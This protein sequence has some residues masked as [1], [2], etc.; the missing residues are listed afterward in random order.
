MRLIFLF[1]AS[2][3][4]LTSNLKAE[5]RFG[6]LTNL[7]DDRMRG[8]DNQWVR[9]HPGPFV[10]NN[11]EKDKGIFSWD[12]V[13]EYVIYAQ[14]HNQ[15]T[16]ATIWP[17]SNWEQK[18]CKR[19]K[20]R[21]PFG[22]RF[23]KYLSKPCSMENYKNFL[24]ALVDRYD[25]DGVNDMPGLTKPIIHWEIMNEPEFKMF[26]KGTED[27]FVEIFNFSSKLIKSKQKDAII[28]MAGAAGMFPESK[29]FWKSALPKIKDH[30]DIANMHHITPPDGKCDKDFWV[31]EFSDL[32]QSLNIDKPIWVTEAMTGVCR[33]IPSYINTFVSG[34]EIIIDV[35]ANAPGM[36]MSKKSRKKLNNFIREV[37]G[38]KSVKLISKK[39]AEFFF[40][41]GSTKIIDF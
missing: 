37:D 6:D 35:G 1:F 33:V 34:A 38:F 18:S 14:N 2:I 25:G 28:I 7:R 30:F 39:Q 31:G 8:K 20:G 36:K 5:S 4:L 23:A 27:E 11:I 3:F 12:K 24:L 10:W 9:P 17:Y 29:K 21:S 15:N 40:E 19:K 13:D 16:I 26:F 41:D 22:K 32:L